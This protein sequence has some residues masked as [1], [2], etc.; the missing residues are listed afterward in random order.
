MAKPSKEN[1]YKKLRYHAGI[2]ESTNKET[3]QGA[4][5]TLIN[6]SKSND[7]TSYGIVKENHHYYIKKSTLKEGHKASDF[8]YVSGLQNKTEYQ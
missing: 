7:G 3:N 2:S 6:V 1:F 4:Q 5:G 8:I